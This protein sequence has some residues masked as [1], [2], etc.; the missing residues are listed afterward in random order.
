MASYADM[1][2]HASF[3][4]DPAKLAAELAERDIVAFSST[5]TPFEYLHDAN[6]LAR[7]ENVR[8]GVGMHPWWVGT[9]GLE[10]VDETLML[11]CDASEETR[12]VGE[13]GLDFLERHAHTRDMQIAVFSR[14]AS[15]CAERGDR[16]VSI[17]CVRAEA[18][19]LDILATSGCAESCTCVLHSYGGSSDHLHAA[20]DLGCLFSVGPRMLATKRGR[21]YARVIPEAS[22]LLETDYPERDGAHARAQEI[23]E[24]LEHALRSLAAIRECD[25][26][27]LGRAVWQR[28]MS[29]LGFS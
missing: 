25:A 2:M 22:L 9:S 6:A 24:S 27:E 15:A 4:A 5:V 1:H 19:L 13:V 14:I 16:L 12:Y 8:L 7:C 29:L 21:E 23:E 20:L 10:S 3:G 17:H 28:S 11:F 18:E 26:S